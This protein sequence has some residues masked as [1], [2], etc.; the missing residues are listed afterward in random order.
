MRSLLFAMFLLAGL[1]TLPVQ[2]LAQGGGDTL[3]KLNFCDPLMGLNEDNDDDDED[4][5]RELVRLFDQER[6]EVLTSEADVMNALYEEKWDLA[7][8]AIVERAELCANEPSYVVQW[9]QIMGEGEDG[10][11]AVVAEGLLSYRRDGTFR[12]VFAKRPYDGTWEFK[13][14]QMNMTASWLNAG[15]TLVV[16]VERVITPVEIIYSNGREKD[17]YEEEIYRVGPFRNLRLST[18]HKGQL[19]DCKCP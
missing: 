15:E 16:P 19:Q 14:G 13:E 6:S 1:I 7:T 8:G 18:T 10:Q 17:S 2:T 12:F 4:Y 3:A 9:T 5:E 11:P